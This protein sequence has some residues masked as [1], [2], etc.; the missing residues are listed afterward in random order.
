MVDPMRAGT[1]P[2]DDPPPRAENPGKWWRWEAH[3]AR[4]MPSEPPGR[5]V[6]VTYWRVSNG[7]PVSAPVAVPRMRADSQS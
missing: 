6:D 2:D 4:W 3:A 5:L 1:A 7:P